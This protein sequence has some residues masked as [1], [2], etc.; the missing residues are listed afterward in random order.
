M[1]KREGRNHLLRPRYRW[2]LNI[3]MDIKSIGW[4]GVDWIDLIQDRNRCAGCCEKGGDFSVSI[5]CREFLTN[6]RTVG[7]SRRTL[8]SGVG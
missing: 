8:F 1:R 7:F 2:E 3:R 5:K 4:D 6:W